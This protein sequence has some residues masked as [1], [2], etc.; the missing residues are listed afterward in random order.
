[1]SYSAVYLLI[2]SFGCTALRVTI[3]SNAEFFSLLTVPWTLY[4]VC[5][6]TEFLK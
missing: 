4:H 3:F 2:V 5:H 6:L 1:M